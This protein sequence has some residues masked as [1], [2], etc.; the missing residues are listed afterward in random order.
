MMRRKKKLLAFSLAA[1]LG[2]SLAACGSRGAGSEDAASASQSDS[3]TSIVQT[4]AVT[5]LPKIDAASWLYNA[6][7]DVYY[8]T[9]IS[10]CENPA[11]ACGC[12]VK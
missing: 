6:E 9:G 10:Y 8:Q 7:D 3:Q 1:V 12:S 2:L 4:E 5:N 11:D